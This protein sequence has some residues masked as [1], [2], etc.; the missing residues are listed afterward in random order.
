[1]TPAISQ[2]QT[3]FQRHPIIKFRTGRNC[4]SF[5]LLSKLFPHFSFASLFWF[6]ALPQTAFCRDMF[7]SLLGNNSFHRN[8]RSRKRAERIYRLCNHFNSSRAFHPSFMCSHLLFAAIYFSVGFHQLWT[9]SQVMQL[10]F[11]IAR[12]YCSHYVLLL[13]YLRCFVCHNQNELFRVP[14]GFSVHAFEFRLLTS[15]PSYD[16]E[17]SLLWSVLAF[18]S[19]ESWQPSASRGCLNTTVCLNSL[20]P[21]SLP[22]SYRREKRKSIV[23]GKMSLCQSVSYNRRFPEFWWKLIIG[24]Y[25]RQ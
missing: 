18:V 10:L 4:N 1:M 7:A 21:F 25:G 16:G 22:A 2:Q 14:D 15:H 23:K 9:R 12:V 3:S 6:P 24:F 19:S 13:L 5:N 11:S 8:C 20:P 17:L